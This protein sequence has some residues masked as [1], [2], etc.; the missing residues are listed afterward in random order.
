[1][2][3]LFMDRSIQNV[4]EIREE[5]DT[6]LVNRLLNEGWIIVA[7]KKVFSP[8]DGETLYY[9]LGRLIEE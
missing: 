2:E 9:H 4:S 3:V 8:E 5:Y 7:T 6:R 1:M